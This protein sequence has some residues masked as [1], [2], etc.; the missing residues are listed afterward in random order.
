MSPDRP[1]P[2]APGPVVVAVL[3]HRDPPLLR[4]LVERVLEGPGTVA[5]VHHDP[6]G[7]VPDLPRDGRVLLVPDPQ[8]CDW[9]RPALAQAMMR[10]VDVAAAAVPDLS[11]FLL[12]SGQDYPARPMVQIEAD[13]HASGCDASLR[14]F[15]VDGDPVQDVHPWQAVTRRRYLK[16]ARLPGTHRSVPVPRR[17]PFH[18]GTGLY[19][20]D[21]WVN[22][23]ARAVEHLL[24][25]RT[26][27][28]AVERYLLRCSIPDEALLPTLLLNDAEHLTVV[29]NR[30]RY[31]RWTEGDAHPAFLDD[32]DAPAVR[33]SGDY[34]ARKVDSV[35]TAALLDR[36]D[37]LSHQK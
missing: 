20:G 34:F 1:L 15:R 13:L 31:I 17:H 33:A 28:A 8:P 32:A 10:C 18:G 37:A 3:S 16:R 21:M 11:W 23:G 27:L 26:R 2:A 9:G 36:L 5:L 35:G 14:W 19:V 25:Q 7:P 29:G 24:A 30:R 22:L 6:R 4:R 12:V